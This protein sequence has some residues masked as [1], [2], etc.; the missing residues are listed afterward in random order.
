MPDFYYCDIEGGTAAFGG[1]AFTGEYI[2]NIDEDPQFCD[3]TETVYDFHLQDSSPCIETGDSSCMLYSGKRCDI[4][5]YIYIPNYCFNPV[6]NELRITNKELRITNYPNP[7]IETTTFS[8][9][10]KGSG[11]VKLEIYNSFGQLVAKP[12]NGYQAKDEQS[13]EWNAANLPAGI[14]FYRV[15]AGE[16]VGS[17][18]MLKL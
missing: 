14:Y 9:I 16:E 3:T 4:G 18:K 13:I 7:I 17:G 15:Q 11:P 10:L 1:A 2:F 8:Y 6:N 5:A 12:V